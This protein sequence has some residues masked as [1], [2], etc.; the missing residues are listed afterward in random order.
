MVLGHKTN[1][2]SFSMLVYVVYMVA[3]GVGRGVFSHVL[4]VDS[5]GQSQL[6]HCL[7]GCVLDQ[8][9]ID[10]FLDIPVLDG[11]NH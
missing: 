8:D 9:F 7:K 10:K 3:T 1:E 6:G 11:C 5:P 2:C 4:Q